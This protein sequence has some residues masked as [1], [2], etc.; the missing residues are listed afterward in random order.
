MDSV[1][2]CGLPKELQKVGMPAERIQQRPIFVH[3]V[4]EH[5][6][7]AVHVSLLGEGL[8]DACVWTHHALA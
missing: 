1:R 2:A 5:C 6:L 8:A 4:S 3:L 7:G